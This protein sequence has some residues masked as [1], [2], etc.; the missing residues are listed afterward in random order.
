M[1][2]IYCEDFDFSS[3]GQAFDGEAESVQDVEQRV[4]YDAVVN[5]KPL[6]VEPEQ[7]LVVTQI[8]EAVYESARTGRTVYFD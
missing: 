8:L 1:L 2:N 7:A 5:G 4:F 6:T 3:L